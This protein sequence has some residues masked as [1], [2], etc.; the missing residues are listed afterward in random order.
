M[1][2]SRTGL[3]M[4]L[5]LSV[6]PEFANR[7]IVSLFGRSAGYKSVGLSA[8]DAAA[9]A[10]AI[11]ESS[12]GASSGS[13]SRPGSG[14]PSG[15]PSGR[16]GSASGGFDFWTTYK[17]EKKDRK[18]LKAWAFV[19]FGPSLLWLA[20]LFLFGSS[21][22]LSA[23]GWLDA[24]AFWCLLFGVVW[25]VLSVVVFSKDCE[26][27]E[28][29]EIIPGRLFRFSLLAGR[30]SDAFVNQDNKMRYYL[31]SSGLMDRLKDV[32]TPARFSW[33]CVEITPRRVVFEFNVNGLLGGYELLKQVADVSFS[34]VFGDA[35]GGELE[36]LSANRYRVTFSRVA[37]QSAGVAWND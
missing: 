20:V 2:L 32:P 36:R 17:E 30:V 24:V 15:S 13:A 12:A 28:E 1:S 11:C 25:L 18:T 4:L 16:S 37:G 21:V 8:V 10:D 29:G 31:G 9:A 19:T 6:G 23:F 33:R 5:T 7:A 27:G 35:D 26:T 34:A 14:V 22:L 3:R